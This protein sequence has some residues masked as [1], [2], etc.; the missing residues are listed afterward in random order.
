[1]SRS[2]VRE[3][4]YSKD[5]TWQYYIGEVAQVQAQ[6]EQ[7]RIGT[8]SPTGILPLYSEPLT[9]FLLFLFLQIP[10]PVQMIRSESIM[11]CLFQSQDQA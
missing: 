5:E 10:L 11:F 7:V 6:E 4:P 8:Q 3:T 1:M 9:V 2:I